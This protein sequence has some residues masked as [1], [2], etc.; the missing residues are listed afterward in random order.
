MVSEKEILEAF[1][2]YLSEENPS[3]KIFKPFQEFS[4]RVSFGFRGNIDSIKIT[5][6]VSNIHSTITKDREKDTIHYWFRDFEYDTLSFNVSNKDSINFFKLPKRDYEKDTLILSEENSSFELGN[7]FILNSTVPILKID[8]TKIKIINKDSVVQSFKSKIKD[9]IDIVFDFEILPN[10]KY[11]IEVLPN[12]ITDFFGNSTDT[13]NYSF[14]TKK[15]SDYGNIYV[16]LSR[17]S[18]KPII[19]D[20]INMNEEIVMSKTLLNS[21]E[22]CVFENIKPGDY[23]LRLIHDKNNNG[24]WDTGDYLNKNKPEEVIHY[25]DTIKVR[26]NWV[27]RERI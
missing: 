24:K 4:N 2:L 3:Y 21:L 9:E 20:L 23:N 15:R 7:K 25:N 12:G 27:I 19:V 6:N 16:N 18:F 11:S 17:I 1:N 8:S 14:T 26:A 13:L 5:S 10:D 22:A